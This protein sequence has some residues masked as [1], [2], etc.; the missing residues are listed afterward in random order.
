LYFATA[1]Q[2]RNKLRE[3]L[4]LLAIEAITKSASQRIDQSIGV[5][6]NKL[7]GD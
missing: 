6:I 4:D 5:G 7:N 2:V 1:L 3:E